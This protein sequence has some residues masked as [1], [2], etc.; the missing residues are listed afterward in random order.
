ML[1]S[2]F[3]A[4]G[5]IPE[6][7]FQRVMW[8]SLGWS[9]ILFIALLMIGW[10]V[11][12]ST[13]MFGIGWLEWV[14]DVLG[15]IAVMIAAM[16]LF[17]GAVVIVISFMLE[18]I[19]E[20]VE[21]KH[22]PDLPA[23]RD[24]GISEAVWT[25]LRFAAIALVLNIVLLPLYFIPVLNVFVFAAVN[26]YLLG[27]EYFELV[28]CRRLDPERVEA[29]RRRYRGRIWMG[30]IVITGLLSIP[31]VNWFLPVVAAASMLHLFEKLRQ[32]DALAGR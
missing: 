3:K 14:A 20:A 32:G 9:L 31:V 17:P 15:W 2:F 19:A 6:P 23:P 5:Q 10:W 16:L 29:M 21:A 25:A 11:I 22:Y 4:T 13:Q 7:A 27:R 12:V 28:A 24:A 8:R 18:D 30:G 1:T 26:G